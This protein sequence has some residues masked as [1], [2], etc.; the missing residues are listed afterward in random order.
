MNTRSMALRAHAVGLESVR[1]SHIH[2]SVA[3]AYGKQI[4]WA[5]YM[6]ALREGAT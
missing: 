6:S 4:I 2:I 3:Y 1:C 5:I